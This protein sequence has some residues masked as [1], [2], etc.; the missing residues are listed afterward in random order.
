MPVN[1][2]KDAEE[3]TVGVADWLVAYIADTL[4]HQ[5]RFTIAL[6]GGN[7]PKQLFKLLASAAYHN[8]IAWQKIHFFWGDERA[9]PFDDERNNAAVAIDVLLSK[10]PVPAAQIHRMET[11]SP[12]QAASAYSTLLHKYFGGDQHSFDLVMLGL[13]ED[14]HTLSVFPNSTILQDQ[15][16]WVKA[17]YVPEQNMWR[18]TLTPVIVNK[19][20]KI[21]FL[22]SGSSKVNVLQKILNGDPSFPAS[23]IQ[24]TNGELIWFADKDAFP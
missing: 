4:Q 9:V 11:S 3:L 14:G 12:E 17:V 6:S 20:A 1:V 21:I 10:V 24:P 5:E 16:N 8:K 19:A 18:I 15:E 2:Y 22:V 7:T 23:K 13:G